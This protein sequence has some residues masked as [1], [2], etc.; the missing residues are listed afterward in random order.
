MADRIG[1]AFGSLV[2]NPIIECVDV[3]GVVREID[4]NEVVERIDINLLLDRVDIN[5]L[6]DRIDI[7]E[8]MK[9]VDVN[10]IVKRSDLGAIIAQSTS[11]VSTQI[12]DVLRTQVVVTDLVFLRL[13][14]GTSFRLR[15]LIASTNQIKLPPRPG[16]SEQHEEKPT[17]YPS[18]RSEMAVDVQGCYSGFYSKSFAILID[19]A[20]LVASFALLVVILEIYLELFTGATH[21]DAKQKFAK[22]NIWV[23][24][25]YCFYW[26]FYFFATV[27]MTGRTLGM[28]FAGTE[29]VSSSGTDPSP[30]Q[31]FVRTM[32]LPLSTTL[33]P[34]LGLI[35]FWRRDGRMLHD[36]VASTGI[37]YSWDAPMAKERERAAA[38]NQQ[39]EELRARR[40]SY[41]DS[42]RSLSSTNTTP[43]VPKGNVPEA[44]YATFPAGEG[45]SKITGPD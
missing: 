27:T 3:N 45:E 21:E 14:R 16:Q 35:G 25:L 5:R 37:I 30:H 13:A 15:G 34:F 24:I 26:W 18:T 40:S 31:I 32:V 12:S 1:K 4:V 38:R 19:T 33:M 2:V 20:F 10:E 29:V 17:N 6:L 22:D 9:R 43:L 41:R 8:L 44:S 42:S 23:L 11:G 7:N 28:A 36:L 39:Q